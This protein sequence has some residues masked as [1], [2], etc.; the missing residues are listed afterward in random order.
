MKTLL[1][2]LGLSFFTGPIK[3]PEAFTPYISEDCKSIDSIVKALYDVISGPKGRRNWDRLRSLCVIDAQ[4]NMVVK[5][6]KGNPFYRN[7]TLESYIKTVGP[8]FAN[9]AFYEVEIGRTV[10]RFGEIA[11]VFSAFESRL[12]KTSRPIERGMNSI[13]LTYSKGRWWIVNVIWTSESSQYPLPEKYL[14]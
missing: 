3:T 11:H 9:S 7:G 13:Q 14:N 2:I 5:D 1:L 12:T 8:V 10:E 6:H 4:F